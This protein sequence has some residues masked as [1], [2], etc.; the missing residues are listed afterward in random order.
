MLW[1]LPGQGRPESP[2]PT[3]ISGALFVLKAGGAGRLTLLPAGTQTPGQMLCG[4]ALEPCPT[5]VEA[6]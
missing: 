1:F 6:N 5:P 4:V 2:A 3:A